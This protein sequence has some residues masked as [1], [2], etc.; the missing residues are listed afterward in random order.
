MKVGQ[1]SVSKALGIQLALSE[2]QFPLSLPPWHLEISDERTL[3]LKLR[4]FP[5]NC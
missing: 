4:G 2:E 5:Q 1:N 3:Y